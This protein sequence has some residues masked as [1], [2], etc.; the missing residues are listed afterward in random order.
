MLDH[1]LRLSLSNRML[2]FVLA[3][4]LAAWGWYAFSNLTVEAFP[5]PTDTQV[6]VITVYPGQPTEE[7]ERRISIPIERA[8]NG[9]PGLFRLRSISLFGLSFVT[10]TFEDGVDPE[11]ARQRVVERLGDCTLPTGVDPK[12]G[13]LATPIGEVYRYTLEGAGAD[14]MTLRTLQD[15]TVRPQL[16]RVPGV[17]DVVSY[18][19][20]LREVHV[21]PDPVKMASLGV[22]LSDVFQALT[23]ASDNATGGYVERGAEVFVIRSIGIFKTLSDIEKV[24]VGFRDGVPVTVK[25]IGT[26]SVGFAPRQGVVSRDGNE[27]TVEGIVLMRRGQNPS[28]VLAAL[29]DR[30]QAINARV[31]PKPIR[32]EPFYDR[33][34]LVDT[35]LKTVFHNLME[36]AGLVVLVLFL[37]TLSVRAAL[38]VAT[39]IPLSLL[40]SFAYLHARGMSANLLSMGAVD[41]GIIVD[42]AVIL[43]EHLFHRLSEEDPAHRTTSERILHAA[44]EVARPTLFSLLIIIAA[45]LPIFSLQRVEGRIFSPM[46]NT[47]V[48]ALIGALLIS[49]TLVPVLSL[50]ALRRHRK[51]LESPVLRWARRAHDP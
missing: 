12:L 37:F 13:P 30:I 45:Y 41:F 34:E 18:G 50:Y 46:A 40:A 49:F 35:T 10:L 5:D 31:L 47:V 38:I 26:V 22:G 51:V 4:G 24:R 33:T 19:G 43:V 32:I 29:R 7:V 16:L 14:P 36:G 28:V 48:S 11:R 42:G 3:A 17:A 25:N 23:R 1:L 9:T 15:W 6:Q 21:T 2:A 27:D 39:V 8:L 44:R 20:L